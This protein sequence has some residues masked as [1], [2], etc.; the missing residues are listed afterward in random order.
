MMLRSIVTRHFGNCIGTLG[1]MGAVLK[2]LEGVADC[3]QGTTKE[4]PGAGAGGDR[5]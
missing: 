4:S 2:V 1:R 5:G 3:G